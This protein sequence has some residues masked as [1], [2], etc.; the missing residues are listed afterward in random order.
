M[1]LW[2]WRRVL[3]YYSFITNF[4]KML[5]PM[6]FTGNLVQNFILCEVLFYNS[7]KH[8]PYS[9]SWNTIGY[10]NKMYIIACLWIRI[11]LKP[12]LIAFLNSTGH[13]HSLEPNLTKMWPRH[14]FLAADRS[15]CAQKNDWLSHLQREYIYLLLAMPIRTC[16]LVMCQRNFIVEMP[17]ENVQLYQIYFAYF[18]KKKVLILKNQKQKWKCGNGCT[19]LEK[20]YCYRTWWVSEGTMFLSTFITKLQN[21]SPTSS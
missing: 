1:Y 20:K 16:F 6:D 13:P 10:P 19:H 8:L 4:N 11:D 5:S 18:C 21:F 17:K 3:I 15:R 14:Y 7:I 12:P 2:K 9:I